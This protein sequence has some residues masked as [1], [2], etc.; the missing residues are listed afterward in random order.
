MPALP[1]D[2]NTFDFYDKN[3]EASQS[4]PSFLELSYQEFNQMKIQLIHRIENDNLRSFSR[5]RRGLLSKVKAVG[6]KKYEKLVYECKQKLQSK[7]LLGQRIKIQ[8]YTQLL[9]ENIHQKI[10]FL[11]TSNAA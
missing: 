9:T 3:I 4:Y 10:E 11:Q 8:C 7:E 1:I 5:L 6:F 2:Y